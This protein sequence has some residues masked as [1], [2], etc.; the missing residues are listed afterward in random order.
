MI[1]VDTNILVAYWNNKDS[2]HERAIKVLKKIEQGVYG[3][4]F[5]TDYIFDEAVT[6][7]SIKSGRKTAAELGNALLQSFHV[8]KITEPIFHE[9]WK[10][11]RETQKL[12][13]TDCTN[14]AAAEELDAAF[15]ATF[16]AD[17][18]KLKEIS[19]VDY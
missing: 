5:I 4:S 11:F 15:I 2:C 9:A 6:V 17:Y 14:A 13:F 12:S 3:T 10:I 19:I 18:K 1:L 16:D 8:A 7:T